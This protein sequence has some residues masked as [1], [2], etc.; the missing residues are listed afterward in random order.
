MIPAI[1]DQWR[2]HFS[3]GRSL[4]IH[5]WADE[6]PLVWDASA[7]ELKKATE[8]SD[9]EGIGQVIPPTPKPPTIQKPLP[10]WSLVPVKMTNGERVYVNPQ[11]ISM[12]VGNTDGTTRLH[13]VGGY[14]I[15]V[16]EA[17]HDLWRLL[18]DA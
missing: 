10:R 1:N 7:R 2:A 17:I 13:F 3:G 9:F 15:L 4:V 6:S 16:A 14:S 11:T 5:G 18:R 12:L 8:F